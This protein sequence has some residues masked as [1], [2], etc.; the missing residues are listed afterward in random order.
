MTAATTTPDPRPL[1]AGATLG[2][3]TV[4]DP[5]AGRR[6]TG[7]RQK[8]ALCRCACG[9]ETLVLVD[10]LRSGRSTGCLA[11][12]R[13]ARR[14]GAD[15]LPDPAVRARWLNSRRAMLDR[16]SNPRRANYPLYGGRGI[17]VCD[18]WAADPVPFLR[19]VAAQPRHA[20]PKVTIERVDPDGGYG[21]GNCRLAGPGEQARNRRNLRWVTYRGRR[22]CATEFQRAF[23]PGVSA[24]YVLRLLREGMKPGW[25]VD[26]YRGPQAAGVAVA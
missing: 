1:A 19:W 5:A 11:C 18:E 8:L 21:P 3:W 10:T 7:R 15:V 17:R 13:A 26:R 9:A 16:C 22:L 2:R 14:V 12:A 20:E 23:V 25:I 4:M 24:Q 6:P